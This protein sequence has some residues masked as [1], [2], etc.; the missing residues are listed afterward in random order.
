MPPMAATPLAPPREKEQELEQ[1]FELDI[2]VSSVRVPTL[3]NNMQIYG[4]CTHTCAGCTNTCN[5][6]H[7]VETHCIHQ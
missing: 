4:K 2:R 7:I 1:E 5:T 6:C 3:V